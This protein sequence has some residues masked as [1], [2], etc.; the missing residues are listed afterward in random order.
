MYC[1]DRMLFKYKK[2]EEWCNFAGKYFW[3]FYFCLIFG[4][5]IL[6]AGH[7]RGDIHKGSS[8]PHICMCVV[9]R[10]N[11]KS[12]FKVELGSWTISTIIMIL[13]IC[14]FLFVLD[15]LELTLSVVCE[16]LF[17]LSPWLLNMC[18]VTSNI[19]NYCDDI[20]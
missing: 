17:F 7:D 1:K 18:L 20:C 15:V 11:R 19:Y 14:V 4:L 2:N 16:T 6:P 9:W 5:A 3:S 10:G 8:V 12:F 13:S